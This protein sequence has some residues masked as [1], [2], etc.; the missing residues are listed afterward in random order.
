MFQ[1]TAADTRAGA[2]SGTARAGERRRRGTCRGRR[3]GGRGDR[4]GVRRGAQRRRVGRP[5]RPARTP[6]APRVAAPRRGPRRETSSRPVPASPAKP[7]PRPAWVA[8]TGRPARRDRRPERPAPAE[9]AAAWGGRGPAPPSTS[10]A[11]WRGCDHR[12]PEHGHRRRHQNRCRDSQRRRQN[13]CEWSMPHRDP[14]VLVEPCWPVLAHPRRCTRHRV[15]QQCLVTRKILLQAVKLPPQDYTNRA[16]PA[17]PTRF[18]TRATVPDRRMGGG[19]RTV[20][21]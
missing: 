10:A 18:S 14:P 15:R 7:G 6:A 8:R 21:W 9:S 5:R 1:V 11:S 4:S 12:R 19:N 13:H 20:E 2:T 17:V 16:S 3:P